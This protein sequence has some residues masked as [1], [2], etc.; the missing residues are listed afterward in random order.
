MDQATLIAI[1]GA[2]ASFVAG[3]GPHL[4]N[5]ARV[6]SQNAIDEAAAGKLRV[7]SAALTNDEWR[8]IA[9]DARVQFAA[10]KQ[11]LDESEMLGRRYREE[12][13]EREAAYITR[14]N[15]LERKVALLAEREHQLE[16][17]TQEKNHLE[18]RVKELETAN[19][20]K[21]EI[22]ARLRAQVAELERKVRMIEKRGTAPLPATDQEAP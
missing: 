17:M 5:R 19:S 16:V 22:I 4:Y 9:E 20:A 11:R 3:I 13:I 14:I 12:A 1:L 2:I 15:S 18:L 21:D 8:E 6:K 7:E 10:L